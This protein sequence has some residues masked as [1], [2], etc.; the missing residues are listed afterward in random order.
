[1][2]DFLTLL[3]ALGCGLVA[4]AFFAFSTF[5]MKALG[6]LPPA[7][8]IAAMQ[9]INVAVINPWFLTPFVGTAATC[10][11]MAIV[12]LVWWN[13]PR[14][15]YWLAGGVLYVIGTFLVTMLF[16]VP[17]NDALGLVASSSPE[18]ASLWVSYLSTWTAWNHVRMIAA[19][20]A[21]ASFTLAFRFR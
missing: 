10:V 7:Q 12:S 19:L 11:L 9:S 1:M 16:N 15:P 6:N 2:L 21:A 8:G 5:V 3:C 17:R 18:A 4:G 14:A 20:A 13:D